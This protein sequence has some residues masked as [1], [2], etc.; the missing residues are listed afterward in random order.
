MTTRPRQ[1]CS[2]AEDGAGGDGGSSRERQWWEVPLRRDDHS[3]E[4]TLEL[5]WREIKLP[6]A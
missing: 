5:S 6:A 3:K 2:P 4:A 1:I